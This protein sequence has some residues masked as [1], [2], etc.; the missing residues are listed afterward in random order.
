M[1]RYYNDFLFPVVFCINLFLSIRDESL[2]VTGKI[3]TEIILTVMRCC[4]KVSPWELLFSTSMKPELALPQ[5]RVFL[6]TVS[7]WNKVN[8]EVSI[9]STFPEPHNQWHV[10][11]AECRPTLTG[12]I[13][14]Y[15]QREQM[16]RTCFFTSEA[17]SWL[18]YLKCKLRGV[19]RIFECFKMCVGYS[20]CAI[21]RVCWTSTSPSFQPK[22]P[23]HIIAAP[24]S[25]QQLHCQLSELIFNR[26][27]Q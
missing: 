26:E 21:P 10:L 19:C 20:G 15:L 18:G 4:W 17:P 24:G 12:C 6:L 2:S 8:A 3:W 22:T 27:S 1:N 7:C 25:V 23:A 9:L 5:G 13:I 14:I 16:E 11:T